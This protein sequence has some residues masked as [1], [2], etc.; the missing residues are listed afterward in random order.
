ML[1]VV[2]SKWGDFPGL[3]RDFFGLNH[4]PSPPLLLLRRQHLQNYS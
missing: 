4:Y 2:W 1:F 3:T